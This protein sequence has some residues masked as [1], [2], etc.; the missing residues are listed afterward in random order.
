MT[1]PVKDAN[2]GVNTPRMPTDSIYAQIIEDFTFALETL[3]GGTGNGLPSRF[4]A[5]AFMVKVYLHQKNYSRAFGFARAIVQSNTFAL[6]PD[7]ADVFKI[8]QNNG[9]EILFSLN[10]A[11]IDPAPM[12]RRSL[13][14]G[15]NGWATELPVDE[16]VG[17]FDSLDRRK[18]V[19]FIDNYWDQNSNLIIIKPHV[20]KFWDRAAEPRGGLTANDI[21]LI[22]YADV[23]LMY[24]EALN[25]IRRGTSPDALTAINSVRARAR[26]DGSED[27]ETLPDLGTMGYEDF[28]QAILAERRR[29]LAWEGHRWFD[30][31]RFE[32]LETKVREAKSGAN[33]SQTHYLFPIPQRELEKNPN[34]GPQNPGY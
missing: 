33:V 32:Q 15:L 19:S 6:L 22:R 5:I 3:P 30:L 17:T 8:S 26:F 29:E 13:P 24:A 14:R 20:A 28:Q 16:L 4:S 34:L 23:L 12:N 27:Q 18:Q 7:Y 31:V 11:A 21:P 9:P 10:Y 2:Q 25:E 1:V